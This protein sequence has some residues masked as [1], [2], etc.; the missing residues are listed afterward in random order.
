MVVPS[1]SR[2][3]GSYGVNTRPQCQA[4]P[5]AKLARRPGRSFGGRGARFLPRTK[6]PGEEYV[7]STHASGA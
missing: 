7:G 6:L 1:E 5:L 2:D 4:S 3:A